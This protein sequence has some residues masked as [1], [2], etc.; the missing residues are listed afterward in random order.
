MSE[1]PSQCRRCGEPLEPGSAFCTACGAS[2][3]PP[4]AAP[5]QAP[6]PAAAAPASAA[7]AAAASAPGQAMCAAHP[8]SPAFD[9][10][11]RCG[12]FMCP[13]CA[14]G[15]E[16]GEQL[17]PACRSRVERPD[18]P[19]SRDSWS[20][21]GLIDYCW[22][23]FKRDW[24][25]LSLGSLIYLAATFFMNVV[26]N[27]IQVA[28]KATGSVLATVAAYGVVMLAGVVLQ[29][30][31]QLGYFRIVGDSLLGLKVDLAGMFTQL[32][33]LG[34]LIV[35]NLLAWLI[36]GVPAAV[37][38]G[39]VAG[40]VYALGGWGS[41]RAMLVV[42]VAVLLAVVPLIYVLLGTFFIQ[43]EVAFSD[44]VSA[45]DAV[46]RSFALVDGQRWPVL[47]SGFLAVII[48]LLGFAA[49]CIG[50]I[51]TAAVAQ[52]IMVGVYFA[53]RNGSG[54]PPTS[55]PKPGAGR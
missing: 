16:G 28:A 19:F 17:C 12:A 36:I 53:L 7:A 9:L 5:L 2:V 41:D 52:V 32:S 24:L 48:A 1:Q 11:V 31:V 45:V 23:A 34:K 37:Y 21:G 3:A 39:L 4:A 26:G 14:R 49:C 27:G 6:P 43:M 30:G 8:T 46:K 40:I 42:A 44:E 35:A 25:L 29:A 33:K 18:F 20:T 50:F 47:F 54:L 38:G 51:P 10:C 15:N 13:A 55:Y 22:Q